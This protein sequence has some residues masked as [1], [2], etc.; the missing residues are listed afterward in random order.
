MSD[1]NKTRRDPLDE[2]LVS[3]PKDVAPERD[4]WPQIRAEIE[5]TPIVAPTP[6]SPF[7]SNWFRLAAA[8]LLEGWLA[9]KSRFGPDRA[10]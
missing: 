5:K 3:L 6:V 7:Q 4:L 1:F 9:R 2:A 10:I 8:V